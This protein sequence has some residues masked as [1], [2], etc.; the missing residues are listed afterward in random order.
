MND[1][2]NILSAPRDGTPIEIRNTWGI[3]PHYGLCKWVL[4]QGWVYANDPSASMIDGPHLD[5]REYA[6]KPED[7][8]DPTNGRQETVEYW[9]TRGR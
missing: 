5:W 2:R 7:Y 1:W 9:R 6:G 8:V 4:G 3:A